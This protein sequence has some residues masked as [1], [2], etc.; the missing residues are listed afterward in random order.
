MI[1]NIERTRKL[2]RMIYQALFMTLVLLFISIVFMKQKPPMFVFLVL[3]V[4]YSLSYI[5]RDYSSSNLWTFFLHLI[6]GLLILLVPSSIGIKAL[7]VL[8]DIYLLGESFGYARF[9]YKLKPLDDIP[10]PTFLVALIVYG[11]GHMMHEDI[12]MNGAYFIPVFLLVIY[13][14]MVYVD[15]LKVYVNATKDVSGLPLKRIVSSNT[16]IVMVIILFL[17]VGLILGNVLGLDEA[18]W[19]LGR[20]FVAVI[21]VIAIFFVYLWRVIASFLSRGGG[22]TSG[23]VV[24]EQQANRKYATEIGESFDFVIKGAV[25]VVAIYIVYKIAVKVIKKLSIKRK[26]VNDIIEKAE[27]THKDTSKNITKKGIFVSRLSG[28]EKIRK[29][30]KIRVLRH[31]YDINLTESKTPR[32]I[33]REIYCNDIGDIEEITDVYSDVRY[34][35]TLVTKELVRKMNRLTKR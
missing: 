18:L 10:W 34:G 28:E 24:M 32:E 16:M 5:I 31:K 22:G 15:G 35:Q 17:I 2:L 11:Y 14:C 25:I 12:M 4:E 30:Y 6:M 21:K 27:V 19:S 13:Y 8:V 26:F 20:G 9:G 1:H 3:F 33:Q 7:L 23:P 29:Y